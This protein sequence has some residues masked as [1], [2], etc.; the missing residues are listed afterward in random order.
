VPGASLISQ[1]TDSAAS[2]ARPA[3]RVAALYSHPVHYIAPLFRRLSQRPEIDLTVFYLSRHGVDVAY[4]PLFGQSFKWDVPL[5]EGYKHK[6]LP[7]LRHDA[8]PGGFFSLMNLSVLREVRLGSYD[9]LLVHG[10]EHCAKWMAFFAARSRG[11]SLV[12]RGESHL[13][14]PRGAFRAFAKKIVLSW[15]FRSFSG[16]ACVGKLNRQYFNA[17]GVPSDR[18][19]LAPYSVD[20]EFFQTAAAGFRARRS[21]LRGALGIADDRPVIL[22]V[23]KLIDV[24]QPERLV[25]AFAKVRKRQACHLL[26]VGDGLLR[27]QIEATIRD[28][29]IPDVHLAGFLNQSRI[30]E[31]HACADIFVLPSR[32]EPWGLA[33]NEA[34]ASGLP[35]VVSDRVGCHPDLVREGSNGYVFPHDD[36]GALA[37]RLS[38]LVANA[39]LRNS[40]GARSRELIANWSLEETAGGIVEAVQAAAQRSRPIQ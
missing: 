30:P 22:C 26:L 12:L 7:N 34:M 33:V 17:Y 14:E 39:E 35:V 13:N 4:D 23:G 10:Y 25:Q 37:D 5:L 21:E 28:L 6:F 27:P 40:F 29:A 3:L 15:L 31:M 11:T 8:G 38:I 19:Y 1:T 9:A 24:K 20:N 16:F 18:L 32:H 2:A 36:T